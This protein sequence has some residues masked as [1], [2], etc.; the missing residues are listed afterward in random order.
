MESQKAR[1][2]IVKA[3]DELSNQFRA[4][5]STPV[6][7]RMVAPIVLAFKKLRQIGGMSSRLAW[8]AEILLQNYKNAETKYTNQDVFLSGT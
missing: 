3:F 1:T 6:E 5:K 7:P 8:A 4:L 2:E